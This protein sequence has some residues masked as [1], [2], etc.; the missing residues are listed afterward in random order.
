MADSS[1]NCLVGNPYIDVDGVCRCTEGA[2]I[3]PPGTGGIR[4]LTTKQTPIQM[5]KPNTPQLFSF[6][7]LIKDHPFIVAG[8]LALILYLIFFRERGGL[9]RRY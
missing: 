6:T 1:C 4:Y 7:N 5:V 2:D 9:M 8:G 3:P